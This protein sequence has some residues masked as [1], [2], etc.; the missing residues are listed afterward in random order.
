MIL[1][2]NKVDWEFPKCCG[3]CIFNYNKT[4]CIF[5]PQHYF[6]WP[7]F[8]ED[9][10]VYKDKRHENCPLINIPDLKPGNRW[11]WRLES[12]TE[13]EALVE[14]GSGNWETSGF[15]D[16]EGL[17][18]DMEEQDVGTGPGEKLIPFQASKKKM[19]AARR[20]FGI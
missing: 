17:I 14:F 2:P 11:F 5:L 13:A 10:A 6:V 4:R 1:C 19:T 3:K 8:M 20:K 15:S 9:P 16:W 12:E 7:T 18:Q